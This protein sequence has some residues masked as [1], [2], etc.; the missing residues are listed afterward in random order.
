MESS[1]VDKLVILMQGIMQTGKE[2]TI[3]FRKIFLYYENN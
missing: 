1:F 3:I 2:G